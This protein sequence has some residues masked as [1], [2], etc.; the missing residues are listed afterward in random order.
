MSDYGGL[1]GRRILQIASAATAVAFLAVLS[2]LML[3]S[4][5]AGDA[6]PASQWR[7]L[8][9]GGG[10]AVQSEPPALPV[11]ATSSD[12]G[13]A[14][15]E[16]RAAADAS[17]EVPSVDVDTPPAAI[18]HRPP[19]VLATPEELAVQQAE[20]DAQRVKTII[21]LQRFRTSHSATVRNA[22]GVA[23]SARLIDLNP[24]INHWYVLELRWEGEESRAYHLANGLPEG[25]ELRV[26]ST[27]SDG[28]L[29]VSTAG[30]SRCPLW[31]GVA[32]GALEEEARSRNPYALL[33][34]GR[35][36]LR[37]QA[38]GQKTAMERVTDFLRDYVPGGEQVTVFVR[39]TLY[40]D[41]FLKT[42]GVSDGA[43]FA[44]PLADGPPA[45]QV[46]PALA[47][48]GIAPTGLALPVTVDGPLLEIGGWYALGD[49]TGMFLSAVRPDAIAPEVVRGYQQRI[50]PIDDVEARAL[51]YLVAFDLSRFEVAF[52]MG[53]D[54]PRLGWSERVPEER[55]VR[56]LPGPDG[57]GARQP[58]VSTGMVPFYELPRAAAAF[59]AGFKRSHGAFR[60]GDLALRNSGSHYGMIESGAVFSKLQPG[61]STLYVLD[62]GSVDL[63]TWQASDDELSMRIVHARQNG[64]PIIER[65]EEP[66]MSV[67]GPDLMRF[68]AGN[69]SGSQDGR[70]RTLRAGACLLEGPERR[71]LVYGYFT[72]ATPSAMARVFQAYGC[73][74]AMLLDMNALEHTYLATYTRQQGSLSVSHLIDEMRVLDREEDGA[75]LPRFLAFADNREFFYLLRRPS[76]A[77]VEP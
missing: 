39:R 9:T 26:S 27:F 34:D 62:D 76:A 1:S 7:R 24:W 60:Y 46:D 47:G 51:A 3:L 33:C 58:L 40:Q 19:P 49:D 42:S 20:Y 59:T 45:A 11:P 29:L 13:D 5:R 28:L 44:P 63:K 70:Y 57:I 41:A 67:P 18:S 30:E 64:V 37:R 36:V 56:G 55:R 69:W 31:G 35:V 68:G 65:G 32:P 17:P 74:Y 12:G 21:E 25:Q 54:H 10:A 50:G 38:T 15:P 72:S 75:V 2:A 73:T 77:E 66:G 52:A 48:R 6:L 8:A 43:V 22:A 61:L 14:E 53:T 16:A 4:P 71:F 23:G